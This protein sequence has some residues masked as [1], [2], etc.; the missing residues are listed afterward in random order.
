MHTPVNLYIHGLSLAVSCR[1]NSV[2]TQ[3]KE[4]VR[5]KIGTRRD[6]K[7]RPHSTSGKAVRCILNRSIHCDSS[8]PRSF[9]CVAPISLYM[10]GPPPNLSSSFFAALLASLVMSARFRLSFSSRYSF[11]SALSASLIGSC[12]AL[13][14]SNSCFTISFS[15]MCWQSMVSFLSSADRSQ[16]PGATEGGD[17][18]YRTRRSV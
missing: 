8:E 15:C 14:I 2:G 5:W 18:A 10:L 3:N 11:A 1:L 12:F 13:V 6:T 4:V 17:V 9:A 7:S 16:L